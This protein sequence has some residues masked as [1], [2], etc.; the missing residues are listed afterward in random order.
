MT[1][2]L[3]MIFDEVSEKMDKAIDR[4]TSE[5]TKIRA[6]K[7]SPAMLGGVMVDY[8]GSATPLSQVSNVSTPDA[9]T[10]T[11]QP[12]EKQLLGDIEK[13]IF[14]ANLG[15]TPQNNG[16]SIMINVPPVT[17]ER[18]FELVKKAKAEGEKAKV[19]LRNARKDANDNV[20]SE[21]KD[22][23]SEDM[24]KDAEAKIQDLTNNYSSKIDALLAEKEKSIMVI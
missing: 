7:A 9:K 10:I 24:A 23:L 20:K 14:E 8:Y 16:E 15:L 19:S 13:A 17:E 3:Q 1:E 21:Q 18:R 5:L 11:I 4:L 22:G 2:E 12:W 6:G